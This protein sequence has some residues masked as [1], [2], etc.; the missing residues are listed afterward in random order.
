MIDVAADCEPLG[1]D[2]AVLNKTN[3]GRER[4]TAVNNVGSIAR[5]TAVKNS[6]MTLMGLLGSVLK[7]WLISGSLPYRVTFSVDGNGAE[8]SL[9]MTSSKALKRYGFESPN[10]AMAIEAKIGFEDV[11]S[12]E[13]ISLWV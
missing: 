12:C 11:N 7:M 3:R 8:G 9:L 6:V 2:L 4:H 1:S 5:T 13:G 10:D